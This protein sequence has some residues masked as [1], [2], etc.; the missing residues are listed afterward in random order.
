MK[1]KLPKALGDSQRLPTVAECEKCKYQAKCGNGRYCKV[2]K[3]KRNENL[4]KWG[5]NK[6]PKLPRTI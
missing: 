6:Q 1:K 3:E 5:N 4:H 2:K